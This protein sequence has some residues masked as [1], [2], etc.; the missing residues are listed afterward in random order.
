M[1]QRRTILILRFLEE[2]KLIAYVYWV[3]LDSCLCSFG[4]VNNV[5]TQPLRNRRIKWNN[6][7]KENIR[8]IVIRVIVYVCMQHI[9]FICPI[10]LGSTVPCASHQL[11]LPVPR[12][13]SRPRPWF[14]TKTW[15]SR[16][17]LHSSRSLFASRWSSPWR[18]RR[19]PLLRVAVT[20]VTMSVK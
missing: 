7:F 14:P 2:T 10:S 16:K 17:I 13:R 5:L 9:F 3:R 18:L 6:E 8:C 11:H 12:T 20:R 1:S 4:K 15:K 19:L